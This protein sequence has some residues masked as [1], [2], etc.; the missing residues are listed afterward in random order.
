[1][2]TQR[3]KP[4]GKRTKYCKVAPSYHKR[5]VPVKAI[6]LT[7]TVTERLLKKPRT[8]SFSQLETPER[9]ASLIRTESGKHQKRH[10][11]TLNLDLKCQTDNHLNRFSL[12]MIVAQR[13][14]KFKP[15]TYLQTNL[16]RM[17]RNLLKQHN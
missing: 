3:P 11:L 9:Q 13:R 1:M 6:I 5:Q 14:Y 17:V 8:I 15:K 2:R 16:P 4:I 7:Q 10:L 12:R